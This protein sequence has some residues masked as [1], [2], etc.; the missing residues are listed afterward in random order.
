MLHR[1]GFSPA[2]LCTPSYEATIV[3]E[4][5]R[6]L[7]TVR[8]MK[9]GLRHSVYELGVTNVGGVS[10]GRYVLDF[11]SV[12]KVL[13]VLLREDDKSG[14]GFV[15]ARFLPGRDFAILF[16]KLASCGCGRDFASLTNMGKVLPVLMSGVVKCGRGFAGLFLRKFEKYWPR[17]C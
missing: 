16:M 12:G 4:F 13:P 11:A 2:L 10:P 7:L 8:Q 3:T 15:S 9:A 14:Q 1:W 17:S 5:R 6:C